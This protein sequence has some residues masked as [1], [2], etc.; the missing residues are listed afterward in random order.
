MS[1]ES[2]DDGCAVWFVIFLVICLWG[3]CQKGEDNQ[4]KIESLESRNQ[5]LE[6]K[7]DAMK[8]NIEHTRN[9]INRIKLNR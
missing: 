6:R 9:D 1:S 7:L 3:G 4:R 2:G 8:I 5:T